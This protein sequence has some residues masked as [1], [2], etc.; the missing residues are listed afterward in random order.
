[1]SKPQLTVQ[2]VNWNAREPL[3]AA[4]R[5]ILAHPPRCE[6]E[7]IVL[8]NASSDG[9][10][11][12][13]EKEFPEVKLLVSEQ[14]LGFSRGHNLAARAAQG[15]Y[16]F[17]LNPDTEVLPDAL[18]LLVAYAEQHP[19]VAI[20]GPKILNPDGSLQYSC[21]R[22]PNPVAALFRNTPLG[23][24]FPNNPY[25]RDYLMTD[26]DHNSI[27][28]VDWVSGAALFIRREVFAQL[29]GFD[30]RFFMYCEDTDLCY[31]AWQAGYKVIYYPEPKIK[32]AIGRSTD[33]VANKMIITFHKSMYL[34]YKKHYADQTS[35]LLRPLVPVGL[36]LRASL[37]LLKN[38]K[39]ALLRRLKK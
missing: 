23:K 7:I 25:T 39:D 14:N 30:E 26:W 20:I 13:L 4:L 12:M 17:I 18:D 38:Y 2:I 10:V 28:E 6:Y 19:D 16:L 21:R 31:R 33:L 27:R 34:F 37:F 8:D 1:M 35:I 29:G 11:Q 15:E 36:A 22:F 32:H 9:S 24:L 5:S 3:R